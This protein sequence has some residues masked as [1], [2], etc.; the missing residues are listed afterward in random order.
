M[1]QG[2]AAGARWPRSSTAAPQRLFALGAPGGVT[3]IVGAGVPGVRPGGVIVAA[4]RAAQCDVTAHA[5]MPDEM[6][7][8]IPMVAGSI[9]STAVCATTGMLVLLLKGSDAKMGV[10]PP[11]EPVH[12]PDHGGSSR[13]DH[14]GRLVPRDK[15]G[16]QYG[17]MRRSESQIRLARKKTLSALGAEMMNDDMAI[18]HGFS[19]EDAMA[20]SKLAA[21]ESL[22]KTPATVLAE[23]Q[24][25]NTRFWMGQAMRPEVS[26]FERRALIMKQHPSVAI[27]G[28]SDS[29][30]PIEI[31]FDQGLGDIF[32]I[33]VAGNCLD[34]TTIGSLEYQ[35]YLRKHPCHTIC[36]PVRITELTDDLGAQVRCAASECQVPC[37]D[38]SRRLWCGESLAPSDRYD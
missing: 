21:A 18:R 36:V 15:A 34:T 28:C 12:R 10:H 4:N 14:G 5:N 16:E 6:S 19:M 33:R 2:V 13:T 38:G 8:L 24:R 35:L 1:L 32:V 20:Q 3:V 9:I 31:V 37:R 23:L 22:A 30:V 25:G 27:L 17:G 7:M 29:R 26:A 11:A